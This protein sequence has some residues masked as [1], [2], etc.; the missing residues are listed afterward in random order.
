M[1]SELDVVLNEH[2]VQGKI[3]E[4]Q[5]A[6]LSA[7]DAKVLRLSKTLKLNELR[8][9][10]KV[11]CVAEEL[12]DDMDGITDDKNLSK[13]PNLNSLLDSLSPSLFVDPGPPSQ[14]A[15]ASLRN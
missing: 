5:A 11:H 1:K 12:G 13:V 14:I 2:A 15:E 3:L 8:A 7:L 10:A 4:K 6:H 9:F